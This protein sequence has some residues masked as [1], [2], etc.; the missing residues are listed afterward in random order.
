MHAQNYYLYLFTK[1]PIFEVTGYRKLELNV[2]GPHS[3]CLE[4]S[5]LPGC[6][7]VPFGTWFSTFRSIVVLL[8]TD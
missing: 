1:A 2:W 7:A 5:T 3:V 6:T 4:F 8:M